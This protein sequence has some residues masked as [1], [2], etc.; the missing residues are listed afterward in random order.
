MIRSMRSQWVITVLSTAFSLLGC[1]LTTSE[2]THFYVLTSL[3]QS[4]RLHPI[5]NDKLDLAVGVGPVEL[6]GYLDRPQMVT[7]ASATRLDMA[8]FEQW[9]EPLQDSVARILA[10]NLSLLLST[11]DV[12]L[13]PW[14]RSTRFD[15]Q[16]IVSILQFEAEASGSVWLRARWTILDD[17]GDCAKC[18]K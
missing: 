14:K 17:S 6:P 5:A 10:E 11:N 7:R 4:E 8:E 3:P 12:E 15:Y 18:R 1:N 16:V 9:A 13:F 2:L